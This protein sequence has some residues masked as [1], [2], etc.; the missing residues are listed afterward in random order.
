MA[1]AVRLRHVALLLLPLSV[2]CIQSQLPYSF[3]SPG[4][5]EAPLVSLARA[6]E[7]HAGP[8]AETVSERGL[9]RTHWENT[10]NCWFNPHAH[11]QVPGSMVRRF[12]VVVAP[13]SSGGNSITVRTNLQC[14]D[15]PVD[16]SSDGRSVNG[17]CVTPDGVYGE[18]Q[19]EV[20][21]LG[22]ALQQALAHSNY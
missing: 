5:P 16:V 13:I 17:R 22:A 10:G 20:D 6:L 2:G 9:L 18:N 7:V 21:T 15:K 19:R 3:T 12:T 1:F 14:C 4:G 8:V 11:P